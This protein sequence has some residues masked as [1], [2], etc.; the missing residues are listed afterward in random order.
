M[1]VLQRQLPRW[2]L[3][4]FGFFCSLTFCQLFSPKP[5]FSLSFFFP[6]VYLCV[7]KV[8]IP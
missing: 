4:R 6:K 5:V 1:R 3:V 7:G 2:S 8:R